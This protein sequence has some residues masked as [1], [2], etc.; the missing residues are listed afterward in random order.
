MKLSKIQ[1]TLLKEVAALHQMPTGAF[2]LRVNGK[3]AESNSTAQIKI[4]PK[5]EAEGFDVNVA[6]NTK[7]QS[8]H[9]PVLIDQ[10]GTEEQVFNDFYIADNCDIVIVAGCGIHSTQSTKSA[11]NGVHTFW[12]GKNCNVQYIEKHL[13][14]GTQNA[15]RSL[16]PTT[17]IFLGQ[18]STFSM[19][20]TQIG[21]V[22]DAQR[23]TI[24]TLENNAKLIVNE[25]I[26]TQH[27]QI[28][29][30]VFKVELAGKNARAEIVSRAVAK[31]NSEQT[32]ESTLIGKNA[33]FGRVE[34]DAILL[35]LANISSTPAIRAEN[36]QAQLS[37]EAQI[38]KIA[39]E[40]LI[41]L[42][43]L[44]LTEKQ[45][46]QEIIAGYLGTEIY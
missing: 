35:D 17:T 23:S 44:G 13:G 15:I 18:N 30:S 27:D 36:A 14:L 5:P 25:K 12:V 9:I 20:T 8:L 10:S 34:C 1:Q 41:K 38:G 45:A 33:C 43:T 40:E 39:G 11:H 31:D 22:N 26:L 46:E 6:K 2:S 32:F 16:C 7:N 28:A 37:H 29:N 21:G 3:V 24:A 4:T 42:M 19:Q